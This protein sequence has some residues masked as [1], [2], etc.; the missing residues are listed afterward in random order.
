MRARQIL[1]TLVLGLSLLLS[2][3]GQA[4][5]TTPARDLNLAAVDLGSGYTM[6]ADEG[7]ETFMQEMNVEQLGEI[8]SASYRTFQGESGDVVLS[9]VLVLQSAATEDNLH[10]LTT[11]FARGLSDSLGGVALGEPEPPALGE[12]AVMRHVEVAEKGVSLSFL[13]FRRANVIGVIAVKGPA[14]AA[15]PALATEFGRELLA[16]CR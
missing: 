5:I 16:K 9:M 8:R 4:L 7:L 10:E 3:G 15:T 14:G 1:L 12:E 6:A 13:G 11:G 2:C